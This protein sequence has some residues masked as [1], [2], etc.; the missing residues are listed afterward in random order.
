MVSFPETYLLMYTCM[1]F[2]ERIA[3]MNIRTGENARSML[4]L[5]RHVLINKT[6]R[7]RDKCLLQDKSR[8]R[9]TEQLNGKKGLSTTE[10]EEMNQ[11]T[12]NCS[13]V[14]F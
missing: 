9:T 11:F 1:F 6:S 7:K 4:K 8:E 13:R 12:T 5:S 10:D 14:S 3:W 2:F